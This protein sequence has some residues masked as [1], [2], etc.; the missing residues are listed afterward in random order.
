[1]MPIQTNFSLKKYNT[2]GIEANAKQFAAVHS[3]T[4]LK[5]ILEENPIFINK[6]ITSGSHKI[7]YL[8]YNGFYSDYDEKLN[9][10]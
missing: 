3:I 2:F 5:T 10:N 7:G 9:E 6:V 4:E 1:M 8:L